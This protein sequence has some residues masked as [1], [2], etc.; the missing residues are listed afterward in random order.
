M[1]LCVACLPLPADSLAS[2]GTD[3]W[4]F[5]FATVLFQRLVWIQ[6]LGVMGVVLD[7]P[8][9]ILSGEEAHL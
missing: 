6:H 2:S 9:V 3:V 7:G 4:T 8:S 5:I 1:P